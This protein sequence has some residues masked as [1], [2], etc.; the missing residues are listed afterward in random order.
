MS[1]TS[2]QFFLRASQTHEMLVAGELAQRVPRKVYSMFEHSIFYQSIKRL[3]LIAAALATAEGILVLVGWAAGIEFL[4]SGIPGCVVM[5][6]VIA[7]LF[8][9]SAASLAL[10]TIRRQ[11]PQV[12]LLAVGLAIPLVAM[13]VISLGGYLGIWDRAP[14]KHVFGDNQMPPNTALQFVLLAVPE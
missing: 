11:R 3:S 2:S 9:C 8:L 10:L 6:P 13:G 1:V 7:V 12:G 14:F 5:K 4:K